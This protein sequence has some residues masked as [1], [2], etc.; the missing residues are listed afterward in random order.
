MDYKLLEKQARKVF[1][2]VRTLKHSDKKDDQMKQNLTQEID[3]LKEMFEKL[4]KN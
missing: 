1:C 2:L 4:R 3:C